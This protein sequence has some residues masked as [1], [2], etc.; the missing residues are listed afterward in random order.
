MDP[1]CFDWSGRRFG[2]R[3]ASYLNEYDTSHGCDPV[4]DVVKKHHT[5]RKIQFRE[6]RANIDSGHEI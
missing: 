1:V 3:A 6:S 4:G 5:D 2:K